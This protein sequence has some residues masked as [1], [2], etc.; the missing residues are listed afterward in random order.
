MHVHVDLF[1]L[2]QHVHVD[3]DVAVLMGISICDSITVFTL[4]CSFFLSFELI[5]L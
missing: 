3:V 2:H 5:R 4:P 1:I